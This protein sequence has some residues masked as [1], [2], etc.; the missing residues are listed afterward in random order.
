[1]SSYI[2]RQLWQG[3]AYFVFVDD[4]TLESI[5]E[6]LVKA[7]ILDDLVDGHMS[8]TATL[9]CYHLAVAC[10]TNAGGTCDDYVGGLSRSHLSGLQLSTR[11]T[12]KL[13][14]V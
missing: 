9:R 2:E 1:M 13:E 14:D 5:V 10:L 4:K 6:S 8:K 11:F 3:L 7:A 12:R